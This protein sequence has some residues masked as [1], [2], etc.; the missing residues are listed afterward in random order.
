M[1]EYRDHQTV[2]REDLLF[3]VEMA[4]RKAG[5][6]WPKRR[7][8][9]DHDRLRPVAEVVVDHLELCGIACFRGPPG[10]YQ[11]IPPAAPRPVRNVRNE[12]DGS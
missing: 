5:R 2:A 6:F 8:P 4:L 3:T 12:D 1:T 7:R 10:R 9:G 11:G